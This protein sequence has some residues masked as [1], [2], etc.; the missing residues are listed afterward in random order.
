MIEVENLWFKYEGS[1]DWVLKNINFKVGSKEFAVIMGPNGS[2]KSTLVRIMAGLIPKFHHGELRG[3]VRVGG[4]D[5]LKKP[6]EVFKVAGF[7]FEDPEVQLV[8]TTVRDEVSFGPCNLGLSKEEI[9]K[10]AKW[11]LEVVKGAHLEDRGT[12]EL[13]L[14][15][16]QKVVLASVLSLKPKVL[17]LDEPSVFLET[18]TASRLYSLL[19]DLTTKLGITVVVVEHEL[20]RVIE[21]ADRII[22]LD[23]GRVI[24]QSSVENLTIRNIEASHIPVPLP[25]AAKIVKLLKNERL[26]GESLT[27][28]TKLVEQDLRLKH[29]KHYYVDYKEIKGFRKNIVILENVWFKYP[30]TL[31]YVLKNVNLNIR[32][33]EHVGILG[34]NG[35]GKSTL[36]KILIGLLKPTR[37]S[38][39]VLGVNPRNRRKLVGKIG[40]VPQNPTLTFTSPTVFDEVFNTAKKL[41]IPNPEEETENVL[42]ITGLDNYRDFRVLELSYGLRRRLSIATALVSKPKLLI[43]D[44]PTTYLDYKAKENLIRILEKI[45]K[46]VTLIIASQDPSIITRLCNMMLVLDKGTIVAYGLT[47]KLIYALNLADLNIEEPLIIRLTKKFFKQISYGPLSVEEFAEMIAK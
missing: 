21:Y 10:R 42:K 26:Y 5:V 22:V 12:F 39:E 30:R 24:W 16:M 18:K 27:R 36:I 33:K 3:N 4:I 23:K 37:G 14:G 2:G 8:T 45:R 40:Y 38:V 1:R 47:R 13:S 46:N 35:S 31:T 41:K 19:K 15:E 44:E 17:V 34:P 11:S 9:V 43:L 29:V 32:D 25:E 6:E 7:I 28:L 20:D